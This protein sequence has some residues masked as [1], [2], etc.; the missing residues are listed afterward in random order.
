MYIIIRICYFYKCLLNCHAYND[1]HKI[2]CS[3]K[4]IKPSMKPTENYTKKSHN[5]ARRQ[6]KNSKRKKTK[7]KK[8]PDLVSGAEKLLINQ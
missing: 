3:I 7:K 2:L 5:K 4:C 8:S 1:V 6:G